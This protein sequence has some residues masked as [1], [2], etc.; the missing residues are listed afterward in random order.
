MGMNFRQQFFKKK[1]SLTVTGNDIFGLYEAD[2][3]Y[4]GA[5]FYQHIVSNVVYPIR[6]SLTYKINNFKR[7]ENRMAKLPPAE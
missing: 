5:G 1:L 7:E 4:T 2:E 6:F 3:R